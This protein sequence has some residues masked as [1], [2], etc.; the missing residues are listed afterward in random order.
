[1]YILKYINMQ[2]FAIKTYIFLISIHFSLYAG[3][4]YAETEDIPGNAGLS[5]QIN[6]LRWVRKV[7]NSN[8]YPVEYCIYCI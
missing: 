4:L 3:W 1:M 7:E 8:Q 2:L 6:A 5:D